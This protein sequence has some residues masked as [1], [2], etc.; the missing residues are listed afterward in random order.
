MNTEVI[1]LVIFGCVVGAVFIG[2]TLN[3]RLPVDHLSADTKE[4]VK[5]AMG[6]LA[7]MS[8]LLL[9][10][11]VASAKSSYDNARSEVIQMAAKIVFLNRVLTGYGPEA[12]QVRARLHEAVEETANRMRP[13]KTN[14]PVNLAPNTQSGNAIYIALQQLT[15]RD[16]MQRSLKAEATTLA[17]ELAQIRTLLVAES[18]SSILKPLLIVVSFWLV[19]IFLTFSLIAPRNGTATFALI[20]SA[21][22]VATAIFLI[23][24]LDRPFSGLLRISNEP[25][26]NVLS[27]LEKS[28]Q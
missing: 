24:E 18:I 17:L 25:M 16:E 10:L 7:T 22:S 13:V 8:A 28:T 26:L 19:V 21:V 20:V 5:L 12:E 11:L 4:T 1:S 14:T 2:R 6:L 15:P 23:L 3:R 27:Q 9:G